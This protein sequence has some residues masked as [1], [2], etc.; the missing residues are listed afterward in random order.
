MAAVATPTRRV[1]GVRTAGARPRRGIP[2]RGLLPLIVLLVLWQILGDE[3]SALFPR[4]STWW[5]AI[6]DIEAGGQLWSSL[7]AT[8]TTFLIALAVATVLGAALG[9]LI[10][11]LRT[12]D[13]AS[14]P[15]VQ[16]FM[17]IPSPTLVPV[18][19]LVIG[20]SRGMQVGVVVFAAIWPIILNTAAGMRAVPVVRL[21]TAR[22]LGLSRPARF[23]KVVLPS[24]A[25]A[26]LLG[27]LVSAP[28][29]IVVTLLVEMLSSA[30]GLGFLLLTSQRAFQSSEVF[31]LLLLIGLLGYLVNA[32]VGLLEQRL[33][34][35]MPR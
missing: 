5:P 28:I 4:P 13:R 15:T 21:E 10:G 32:A 24:V 31:G 12:A 23:L 14:G 20:V 16:F 25:P 6:K 26:A 1:F 30:D 18:A 33:L 2:L 29:C 7:V 11:S 9:V 17:S 34:R 19:L 35:N 8:M 22:V 27:V 3:N